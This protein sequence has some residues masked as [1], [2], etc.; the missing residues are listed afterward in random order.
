MLRCTTYAR[1]A[2]EGTRVR[3]QNDTVWQRTGH[4]AVMSAVPR[5]MATK[6]ICTCSVARAEISLR[7][8]FTDSGEPPASRQ[9]AVSLP[10]VHDHA[11]K[12]RSG[13]PA[14]KRLPKVAAATSPN[15]EVLMPET[16]IDL[17][18]DARR[19]RLDALERYAAAAQDWDY[20]SWQD[21]RDADKAPRDPLLLNKPTRPAGRYDPPCPG[22]RSE[23]A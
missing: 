23:P 20:A 7:E 22:G 10:A 13:P 12:R 2:C 6:R 11:T 5:A 1:E 8:E 9:P 17:D 15:M 18:N 3:A 16:P 21:R 14:C 19:R 4:V